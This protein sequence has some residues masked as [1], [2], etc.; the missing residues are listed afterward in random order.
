MTDFS[1]LPDNFL[2]P[3]DDGAAEP[4][5]RNADARALA[6]NKRPDRP[7]TWP[8]RA[9]AGRSSTSTRLPAARASI[10]RRGGTRSPALAAAGLRRAISVIASPSSGQPARLGSGMSSQDPEYQGEAAE[11]LHLPF[12]MI[13]DPQLALADALNLPTFS[14]HGY[15]R[16]YSRSNLVVREG[17]IEHVF[18]PILPPSTDARQVLGWP[19]AHPPTQPAHR[20]IR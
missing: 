17:R 11:R 18:Y 9:P 16:V 19:R 6:A 3:D 5:A 12:A 8:P 7:S 4:P 10:F 15:A 20:H 13:S 14:A 2:A 1:T